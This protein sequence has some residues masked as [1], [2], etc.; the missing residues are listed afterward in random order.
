MMTIAGLMLA[1]V[2]E[3]ALFNAPR[4]TGGMMELQSGFGF[5]TLAMAMF[6]LPEAL[7][8]V[9]EPEP[10]KAL[11]ERRQDHRSAHHPRRG[12]DHRPRHRA[13]VDP[14]LLHRRS[15]GCGRHDRVV[16]RLRGGAQHRL[17]AEEQEEFGK[18]SIKGLAAPESANNAACYR[19]L[20][21]A[22]DARHSGLGHDGDP[23][24]RAS[25]A[26]RD[27]GAT[28][29]D[30]RRRRSSGPSSS[31]CII[32]NLVL[33]V[34]NLPLIPYIA[35]ILSIPRNFL[36]PFILFFTLMGAYIGQNNSTELLLLVGFGILA[37]ILK[38]ADYPA[39]AASDRVHSRR[40]AGGQLRPRDAAL[41]RR[42]LR[43]GNVP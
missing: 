25:G 36:I 23:A 17:Q 15:A 7:F 16:P 29:D 22:A 26:E 21:A 40:H 11:Q 31:R 20:R 41:R 9:L 34:L 27:A 5:I 43:A 2:G 33:L 24:R 28:P 35:K 8:L 6:A 3:G 37:T 19:I 39:C 18:G 13:P 38:F 12:A 30:R 10:V 32:G 42:R 14:G 4:F 1:T